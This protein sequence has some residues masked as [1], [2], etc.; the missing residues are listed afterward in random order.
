MIPASIS[1]RVT[2]DAYLPDD[3]EEFG[4]MRE[5]YAT[6]LRRL[7]LSYEN[8]HSFESANGYKTDVFE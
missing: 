3:M 7:S 5:G 2:F 8:D 1:A 4:E 6:A